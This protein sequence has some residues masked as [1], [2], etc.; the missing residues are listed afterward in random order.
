[1]RALGVV[2]LGRAAGATISLGRQPL[3]H[4]VPPVSARPEVRGENALDKTS[5]PASARGSGVVEAIHI[6][7]AAGEPVRAVE[8]VN[9][10]AGVGLDGDRYA[11]GRGHYQ[12]DR[13]RAYPGRSGRDPVIDLE[14][15]GS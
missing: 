10:V 1:M 4:R 3:R 6:A 7:A 12:D 11:Y 13:V 5:T 2:S 15:L 14:V 9:A 8:I